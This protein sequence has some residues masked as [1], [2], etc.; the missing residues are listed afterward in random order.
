[1]K[2]CGSP[3]ADQFYSASTVK[4]AKIILIDTQPAQTD[5][6]KIQKS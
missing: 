2:I 5:F 6:I 1:M 3:S 4:A